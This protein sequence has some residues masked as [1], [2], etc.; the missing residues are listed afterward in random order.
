MRK[1]V[2]VNGPNNNMYGIRNK[3]Q[4]GNQLYADLIAEL[5][6]YGKTLGFEVEAFQANGEG[7]IIDYFQKIYFE[8]EAKGEK[9]PMVLNPGAFTHYS[10]AIMDALESVHTFVPAI[11]VHMSNIHGRDDFRHKS[12]TA[13]ECIGQISGMGKTSY[14]MAMSAFKQIIED[15]L[16]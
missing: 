2:I 11:E 13:A 10:Y 1:L 5:I 12:V 7:E 6:E 8:A 16:L 9:I 3:G 14:K 15:G 4:Y